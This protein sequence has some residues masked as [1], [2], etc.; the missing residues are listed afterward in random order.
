MHG[1]RANR[2]EM[3]GRA[4]FLHRHGM[5]VLLFDFQAHGESSGAHITFG[6]LEALDAR[7]A[8][9]FL[10]RK[11]PAERIGV[12]G[13]S[14]GGAAAVLAELQPDAMVLEAVYAS[15]S[16][17]VENRLTM[18]LGTLGRYLEPLLTW[19]M[20]PRLGFD[21]EVLQPVEHIARLHAPVLFLAGD[22]DRHAPLNETQ[23]LYE[24][25]HEPKELWVIAGAQHVDFHRFAPEAYERR[26]VDFLRLHLK[27][28]TE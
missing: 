3:L 23:L 12:I 26:I 7:A 25:A 2:L 14:L 15:F 6:Y 22:A 21:P 11:T 4:R 27:T 9:E 5:A 18:R 16:K 1:V 10:R 20:R 28:L 8:F 17:A 24:R 19:Q 13:V